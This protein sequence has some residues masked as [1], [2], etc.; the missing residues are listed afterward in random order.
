M[1]TG[2]VYLRPS[3]VLF[4]R[5]RGPLVTA[6][7]QAWTQL[8][9]WLQARGV[10]GEVSKAY[11]LM[12]DA[13]GSQDGRYDACVDVPMGVVEDAA[14]GVGL[15][16]LPGGAYVRHRHTDGVERTAD[17]L[18]WMSMD[19]APKR[20]MSADAGRPT[21]EVYL[22]DPLKPASGKVRMDLCLPV[23][24]NAQRRVA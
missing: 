16:M 4:V 9:D 23:V 20:G 8:L 22:C 15:Q 5:T 13:A 19:W 3:P 1:S 7:A 6:S 21:L 24:A 12:R 2:I 18:N 17:V 10:R 14:A 11:G